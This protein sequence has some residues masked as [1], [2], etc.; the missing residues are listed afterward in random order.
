VANH[1]SAIKKARS[2]LRKAA[3]NSKTLKEVR[4]LE[5]KVRKTLAAKNKP[6]SEKALVEFTSKVAKAAQK[7][8]LKVQTASRKIGRLSAQVSALK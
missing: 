1:K 2:S 7:G 8:R 3:V 5:A 4:T 6:E